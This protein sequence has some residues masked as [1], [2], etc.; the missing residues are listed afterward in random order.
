MTLTN[1]TSYYKKRID[2]LLKHLEAFCDVFAIRRFFSEGL[3]INRNHLV[4]FSLVFLS[5]CTQEQKQPIA[6][7]SFSKTSPDSVNAYGRQAVFSYPDF[8]GKFSVASHS[9]V[10]SDQSRIEPFDKNSFENRK[11]QVRFYYPTEAVN[12]SSPIKNQLPVISKQ[13]WNYLVGLD[14]RVGKMLRFNNYR[15]AKWNIWLDA[16]VDPFQPNYPV[17]VFSH[18]YGYSAESYSALSAELASKG[19]IVVSINHTYGANHSDFGDN[20][21][22][23]AQPLPSDEIGAYLPIWSDDQMFVIE[24][25]NIINSDINSLF[26]NKL[27][28]SNL[29]IFG[30]S[31]GG[32]AS[33]LTASRDPQVKAVIDIDGTIFNYEDRYI[34][35]PFA[36]I[37]SKD[38]RP[39]FDFSNVGNDAYQIRL[40]EFK[41]VSFTDYILWWQWDHDDQNLGLGQVN[42]HRAV[43]LTSEIVADFFA[44]YLTSE[45][46]QWFEN[47]KVLTL[48]VELIKKS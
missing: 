43:E 42:A 33:Y 6:S 14:K 40:N 10:I 36:F 37:I 27:D 8:A 31:Y 9:I 17:L 1:E 35:Q 4:I 44:K 41:H 18:G 7:S 3:V 22:V 11:L 39:K 24:Q 2:L 28:L 20:D 47:D 48:E 26:Y 19:Y 45:T 30:H 23:W 5:A 29:G 21:L 34:D 46:S 13:A 38:H 25:L 32:A 15:T 16:Q 12:D